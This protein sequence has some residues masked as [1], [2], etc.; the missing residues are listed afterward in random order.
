[1]KD[2]FKKLFGYGSIELI[3]KAIPFILLPILTR[4]LTPTEYGVVTTYQLTWQI[5]AIFFSFGFTSLITVGFH[6]KK[7]REFSLL[8]SNIFTTTLILG[9]G[10]QLLISS[11]ILGIYSDKR[12]IYVIISSFLMSF[13]TF[14]LAINQ[15]KKNIV[16]YG[17]I[18][19]ALTFTNII[20]SIVLVAFFELGIDGRII[21]FCVSPLFAIFL[22]F[23]FKN[24][25]LNEFKFSY[26]KLPLL[27]SSFPLLIHQ[28]I[29]WAR[30]SIDKYIILYLLGSY[31][32]GIYNVN[33]QLAF[34][35]SIIVM[36]TNRTIQPIL[37]EKLNKKENALSIFILQ[38]M[39]P[40]FGFIFIYLF[41]YLFGDHILGKTFSIE[42]NVF[43]ILLLSFFIQGIYL[44]FCNY[45]YFYQL[46]K[47]IMFNSLVSI[48][49]SFGISFL[50]IHYFGFIGA[51]YGTLVSITVLTIFT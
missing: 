46:N 23:Y 45:L 33:F 48:F 37:F 27:Y 29:N 51:A 36:V 5:L 13:V 12:F 19:I 15:T 50:M 8:K 7:D 43:F 22:C 3:N 47:Q 24:I 2:I 42:N 20:F 6:K 34:S 30:Y 41:V 17:I 28:T 18:Q 44:S 4:Y 9:I 39:I 11:F 38:I 49:S 32:L 31:S 1:M 14:C 16:H 25:Q 10:M 40:L 26:F 35:L 21:G